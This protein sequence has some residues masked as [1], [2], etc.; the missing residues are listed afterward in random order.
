MFRAVILLLIA[1]V[2][3]GLTY[4]WQKAALRGLPPGTLAL[5]RTLVGLACMAGWLAW[6]RE[7]FWRWDRKETVRLALVGLLAYA[8]PQLLGILGVGLSTSGNA[9]ILILLEPVSIL[10]FSWWLLGDRIGGRRAVGVGV[11]MAGALLVVT[12]GGGVALLSSD[13]FRG[14]LLL[15]A[16]GILWGLWTP[17]M[18]GLAKKHGA[19][20]NTLGSSLFALLLFTPWALFETGEWHGGADLVPSLGYALLLGVFASFLGTVFWAHSL[21]HLPSAVVAPFVL[22]Q[23]AVGAF[24]GWWLLG[25]T[26]S[27]RA[28]AGAALAGAGVLLVLAGEKGEEAPPIR[29]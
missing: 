3:G 12:E 21:K 2:V 13:L 1:N 25:E 4:P 24:M 10:L 8:A 22:L 7:L 20:E 23:P 5:V 28:L 18:S 11:G 14:N 6:K 9:S 17:L 16:S 29:E 15:A 19:V 26:L 27:A